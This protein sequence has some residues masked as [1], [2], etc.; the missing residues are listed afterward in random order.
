MSTDTEKEIEVH[1]VSPDKIQSLLASLRF[2]FG[3]VGQT[4]VTGCWAFLPSGFC[5]AYGESACIDPNAYD[6]EIGQKLALQR[7]L[8]NAQN[9]LWEF[10]GYKLANAD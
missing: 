6:Q 8:L 4:T 1:K 10:E 2:E 5:V 9:R 7:C 3:R